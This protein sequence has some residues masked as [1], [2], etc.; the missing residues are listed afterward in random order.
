MPTI[1]CRRWSMIRWS[2]Q[3]NEA[4]MS[5]RL[6]GVTF[7][8][9]AAISK[10]DQTCSRAVSVEWP[11]LC[12]TL[13]YWLAGEYWA[14]IAGKWANRLQAW[15]NREIVYDYFIQHSNFVRHYRYVRCVLTWMRNVKGRTYYLI[16]STYFYELGGHMA[17]VIQ[18]EVNFNTHQVWTNYEFNF[19]IQISTLTSTFS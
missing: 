3:S 5:S 4:D 12:C 6:S 13:P 10:S 9:S 19:A 11:F 18:R 8:S 15:Y 2:T 16:T 1:T 17:K 7:G 14:S